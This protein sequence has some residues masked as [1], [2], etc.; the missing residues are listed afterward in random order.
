[1]EKDWEIKATGRDVIQ[2]KQGTI[3]L[4]WTLNQ[5]PE[6]DW[7]QFLIASSVT[8]SGSM[9]FLRSDPKL[10][11]DRLRMVVED[12][13]LEAAVSWIEQSIPIANQKFE[14]QVLA[15]RRREEEQRRQQEAADQAELQQARDRLGRI[16]NSD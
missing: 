4:E 3:V 11:G 7:M 1:M 9:T 5:S 8:K 14:S 12:R 2:A 15:K 16:G 13:D 10:M 6:Q